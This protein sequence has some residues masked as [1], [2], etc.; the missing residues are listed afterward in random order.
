MSDAL[1]AAQDRALLELVDSAVALGVR[2]L[3]VQEPSEGRALLLRADELTRRGIAVRALRQGQTARP[4]GEPA[5]T[6]VVAAGGSGRMELVEA[7]CRLADDGVA[8]G[9]VDERSLARRLYLP[10]APEPDLLVVSG[11]E[12]RVPDLLLWEVAYSELVFL[13]VL[14]PDVRGGHLAEA[15]VE[16]QGR[17]RR[18]G[19]LAAQGVPG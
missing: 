18:Y 5:L 12:R 15:V 19:G 16:Y 13:D 1:V 6:V 7:V 4:E 11:G 10:E 3:T 14:W 17:D 8:P 2:W 9:Q